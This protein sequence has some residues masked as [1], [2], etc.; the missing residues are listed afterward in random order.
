MIQTYTAFMTELFKK[1]DIPFVVIDTNKTDKLEIIDFT[2]KLL[3]EK[4]II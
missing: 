2:K 4:G 1:Y 3:S